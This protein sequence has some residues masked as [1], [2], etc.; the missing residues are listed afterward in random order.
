MG[1]AKPS[2]KKKVY[3]NPLVAGQPST[4]RLSLVYELQPVHSGATIF[5]PRI[6][7]EYTTNSSAVHSIR[8]SYNKNLV[9]KP[10]LY[11]TFSA[12]YWFSSFNVTNNRNNSFATL[13]GQSRFHSVTAS[14]NIFR[15][16][17]HK[18]FL[19][20]NLSLE[21]N[22]NSSSLENLS[23]KNFLA[24]GAAIYGWKKG[25]K[26]MWGLGVF[27]GYRLGKVIHVP[28]LLYNSSFNMKW[29]VDA[30]LPARANFRYRPSPAM[31]W[32]FG[33]ELD[34][35]QFALQNSNPLF[36]N[37]FF[38]RGEIRPKVGFERAISKNWAFTV[39]AGLRVNG[40]FDVS[41]DYAG[42]KVLVETNPKPSVFVNA[43]IHIVNLPK[44]K[45]SRK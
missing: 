23:G 28:A 43:G 16:L 40:R 45:K 39:N 35:T 38:Q 44:K 1:Q 25:F 7:V 14:T 32:L 36:N 9:M 4:K 2:V 15:P 20:L 10:R 11:M 42:D 19:L 31:Q 18:N 8:F 34:G 17:N 6:P 29:G 3:C 24:G 27:R 22:G 41:S 13:L 5:Q 37:S 33:Y 26:R 30:L 21:V 12:G